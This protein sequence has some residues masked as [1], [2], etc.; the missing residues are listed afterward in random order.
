ME[1]KAVLCRGLRDDLVGVLVTLLWTVY[2]IV[3]W[4]SKGAYRS[5]RDNL[6]GTKVIFCRGLLQ[7]FSTGAA[8]EPIDKL[9]PP[10][11][12]IYF[13]SVKMFCSLTLL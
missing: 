8:L 10:P 6:V 9:Q 4:G 7:C 1:V 13:I 11:K 3:G 12:K 2:I 5:K